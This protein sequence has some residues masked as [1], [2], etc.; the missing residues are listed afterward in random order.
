[1]Q[2]D[3]HLAGIWETLDSD[4]VTA[5]LCSVIDDAFNTVKST[6][7]GVYDNRSPDEVVDRFLLLVSQLVGVTVTS[8][9][10][11]SAARRIIAHAISSHS[12]KGTW[13]RLDDALTRLGVTDWETV[14]NSSILLVPGC[15]GLWGHDDCF[16]ADD[17]FYHPGARHL[18]VR[19]NLTEA[20][21]RAELDQVTAV[22]EKWF[23]TIDVPN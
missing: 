18:I 14:D 15:N 11:M 13:A 22:G 23:I 1:M 3:I 12:Y 2:S 5:T 4:E 17:D 10:G 20:P 21:I 16:L 9:A 6:A 8:T 7:E 19:D